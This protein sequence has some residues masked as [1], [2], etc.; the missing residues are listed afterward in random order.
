[1]HSVLYDFFRDQGS[2]IGGLLAL[3]AGCLA[4]TGAMR[5]AAKQVTAVN[6]QTEALRQ[7]NSHLKTESR[8]RLAREAIIA[9]K[10]LGSVLGIVRDDVAKVTKLLD[11]PVYFGPNMVAPANIRQV[12]YQLP[13]D[14]VW[15]NL[16]VCGTEVVNN[17]L[18][19]D[20]K[21]DEFTKTQAYSV[22]IIKNELQIITN[23]LDF[24]ERELETDAARCNA[25]ILETSQQD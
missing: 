10:L 11:Q 9:I 3:A 21:L 7:Q 8:R 23:I 13:L 17:Y 16:S 12:I 22:D 6:A 4:F 20:A 25:V 1:M 2:I 19:L 15:G 14:I 24:L 18:L 5:A